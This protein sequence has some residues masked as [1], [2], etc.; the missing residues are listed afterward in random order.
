MIPEPVPVWTC[1]EAER[2][3][4]LSDFFQAVGGAVYCGNRRVSA[5]IHFAITALKR[6]A[7]LGDGVVL[8]EI[9][10]IRGTYLNRYILDAGNVV[11]GNTNLSFVIG[12][13]VLID[14]LLTLV[15]ISDLTTAKPVN[16]MIISVCGMD[17]YTLLKTAAMQAMIL[18]RTGYCIECTLIVFLMTI[19][20]RIRSCPV[21][22]AQGNALALPVLIVRNRG[23]S[24]GV[25]RGVFY[26]KFRIASCGDYE[27]TL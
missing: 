21:V 23:V 16:R 11:A 4:V 6:F 24:V 15:L 7:V 14:K 27:R 1:A 10:E 9:N 18:G 13:A 5:Q 26:G 20:F 2:A 22:A 3:A 17:D 19:L 25:G 8:A 12:I